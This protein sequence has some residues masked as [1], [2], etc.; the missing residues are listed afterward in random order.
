MRRRDDE[1]LALDRIDAERARRPG[2]PRARAR[3]LPA[4]PPSRGRP[5]LS[6]RPNSRSFASASATTPSTSS[7]SCTPPAAPAPRR[8]ASPTA[9]AHASPSSSSPP[10]VCCAGAPRTPP[11]ARWSAN[12]SSSPRR[13]SRRPPSASATSRSSV[14]DRAAWEAERRVAPRA[15][16]RARRAALD[17][18]PRAPTRRARATSSLPHRSARRS[19]RPA[20]RS[21]HLAAS[22]HAH[23]GLPLRPRHHRHPPRRSDHPRATSASARTGNAHTTT[24]N[25]P[26][27]TSDAATP[28]T[29]PRDLERSQRWPAAAQSSSRSSSAF[30]ARLCGVSGC[31]RREAPLPSAS[32]WI[33]ADSRPIPWSQP[34]RASC[35]YIEHIGHKPQLRNINHKL[36]I[37]SSSR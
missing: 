24:S 4:E 18:P 33:G 32:R 27:E 6:C 19:P 29:L 15:R 1:D 17:P 30:R 22:R 9:R 3:R 25:A 31:D 2:P 11:N 5:S 12:A 36:D 26:N 35:R 7:T 10:A 34:R 20:A 16:R 21:P 14:P 8:S 37:G 28:P 13:K 23:R